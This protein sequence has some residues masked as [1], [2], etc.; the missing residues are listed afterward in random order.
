MIQFLLSFSF[1]FASQIS[2]PHWSHPDGAYKGSIS[3]QD[4]VSLEY[5]TRFNSR[6]EVTGSFGNFFNERFCDTDVVDRIEAIEEIRELAVESN[7]ASEDIAGLIK[8]M[9]KKSKMTVEE[10]RVG[11]E[12]ANSGLKV[13]NQADESF[14]DIKNRV[15]NLY[16]TL[17]CVMEIMNGVATFTE[18]I[19]GAAQEVAAISEEQSA[20]AEETSSIAEQLD[21]MISELHQLVEEIELY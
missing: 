21:I 2:I 1:L 12:K 19:S 14:T 4:G 13:I 16:S 11:R 5:P 6:I 18:D 9:T 17:D 7:A 3:Q 15:D 10:M 20:E 8:D